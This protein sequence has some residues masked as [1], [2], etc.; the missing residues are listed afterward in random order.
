MLDTKVKARDEGE[1]NK[2]MLRAVGVATCIRPAANVSGIRKA[3]NGLAVVACGM[4]YGVNAGERI[5]LAPQFESV[6]LLENGWMVASRYGIYNIYDR[7]GNIYKGLSF[8]KEEN[9][10]KF[11]KTL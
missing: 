4:Q 7:E 2:S 5:V 8:L 1:N 10:I 6:I 9:A 11:A 3:M